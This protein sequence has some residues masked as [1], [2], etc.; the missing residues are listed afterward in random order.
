MLHPA[1]CVCK[2]WLLP[3]ALRAAVVSQIT[4][5]IM[6]LFPSPSHFTLVVLFF[7]CC[8]C[9]FVFFSYLE[10]IIK[11]TGIRLS[12]ALFMPLKEREK[13]KQFFLRLGKGLKSAETLIFFKP[14]TPIKN[15]QKKRKKI[16]SCVKCT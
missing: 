15:Q 10:L 3:P 11:S 4:F 8:C 13:N 14:T 6:C 7:F 5:P 12:I 16:G 2:A 1:P 9:F